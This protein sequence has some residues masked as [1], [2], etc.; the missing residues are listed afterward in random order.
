MDG[1]ENDSSNDLERIIDSV[2]GEIGDAEENNG[3]A[4]KAQHTSLQCISLVARHH[5]VD[6]SADRLIHDY[7]LED[8]EPSL[9]RVMRIAKDIGFKTR[10]V[11][12]TWK[13][14]AKINDAF[15]L[16]IRLENGNYVIAVGFRQHEIEDGSTVDQVAIF[17]P[18]ADRPDF[19]FLTQSEFENGW[20]GEA[21][22]LK[23]KYSILDSNQPFSLKWFIRK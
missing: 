15:P 18:L 9:N 16:I 22:F 17:D 2:D 3:D 21:I 23:R 20:K 5:G 13:H 14:L 11:R 10:H 8:Q 6:V 7:S 12:L 4:F 19:L 1:D